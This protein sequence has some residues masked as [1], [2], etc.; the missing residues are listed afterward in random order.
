MIEIYC[1][2][3]KVL[4]VKPEYAGRRVKCPN[5]QSVL[6]VP[7][8]N[9]SVT[10]PDS[11]AS[12]GKSPANAARKSPGSAAKPD[13]QKP[14]GE[15]PRGKK[16]ARQK[17]ARVVKEE[18]YDGLDDFSDAGGSYDDYGVDDFATALPGR[19]KKKTSEAVASR[20]QKDK[21]DAA[22]LSP[23]IM[24]SM[25][26]FAATVSA[27][28]MFFIV[29]ALMATSVADAVSMT[30]PQVFATVKHDQLGL[31]AECPDERGWETTFGGGT[32]GVAPWINMKHERQGVSIAI[33]GSTSGTAISDISGAGRDGTE[34]LPDELQ[35]V[36]VAHAFQKDKISSDYSTYEET[37]PRKIDSRF[38]EGR[39][40]D[41]SAGSVL[42]TEHGLRA[43]LI[44]NQY[45]YNVICKA[46]KKRLAEYRAVFERIIKSIGG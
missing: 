27:T 35:P 1:D 33:R 38:G 9:A 19:K 41:F 26:A 8:A 6:T 28:V 21:P 7:A 22:G 17:P 31:S 16:S 18:D 4:R 37:E 36:S 13:T 10:S 2:C 44:A 24:Y 43:S 5:C 20:E 40:S 3:Q 14:T 42:S 11:T 15:Q 45:Q 34:E 25:F 32:G 39:V 29:R 46:P 23:G 30:V 12:P